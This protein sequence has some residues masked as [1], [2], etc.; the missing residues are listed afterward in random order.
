MS[1]GAKREWPFDSAQQLINV[2]SLCIGGGQK[3]NVVR[4]IHKGHEPV[5]VSSHRLLDA[6]AQQHTQGVVD[7]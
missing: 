2:R 3:V 1:F 5:V 4:H 7:K 6:V